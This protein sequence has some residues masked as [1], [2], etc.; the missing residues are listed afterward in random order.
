MPGYSRLQRPVSPVDTRLLYL[1]DQTFPDLMECQLLYLLDYDLR[2][3]ETELIE[4]F[5]P[6]F[7]KTTLVPS[8]NTP[9]AKQQVMKGMSYS[10]SCG[11]VFTAAA[12]TRAQ[13]KGDAVPSSLSS[14]VPASAA[15]A[16]APAK[17]AA[18]AQP[19]TPE[20]GTKRAIFT[21]TGGQTVRR[22]PPSSA[23]SSASSDEA[24]CAE[25]TEDHASSDDSSATSDDES[26]ARQNEGEAGIT[27]KISMVKIAGMVRP[28]FMGTRSVS[29]TSIVSKSATSYPMTPTSS[30]D[31]ITAPTANFRSG[32]V[33]SVSYYDV[34]SPL[35]GRGNQKVS[36]V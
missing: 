9:I 2:I 35:A 6:F 31:S 7:K 33:K 30:N 29:T 19:N 10:A 26:V 11:D 16:I 17:P 24:S 36:W 22:P 3:D 25:L 20:Q 15:A 28:R 13:R 18:A 27:G 1:A 12:G 32:M 5:S 4:H 21:R 34:K 8:G 23:T 14:S